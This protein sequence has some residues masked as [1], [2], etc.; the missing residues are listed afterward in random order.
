MAT[1]RSF[2]ELDGKTLKL[3]DEVIEVGDFVKIIDT[4][5]PNHHPL[6]LLK[7]MIDRYGGIWCRVTKLLD[8]ANTGWM[9]LET[10]DK[11]PIEFAWTKEMFSEHRKV[12]IESPYKGDILVDVSKSSEFSFTIDDIPETCYYHPY[13]IDQAIEQYSKLKK[14]SLKRAFKEVT[15]E[16]VGDWFYWNG[17][18][19]GFD[20]WLNIY[21]N[22]SFIPENYTPKYYKEVRFVF[23][24]HLTSDPLIDT[25]SDPDPTIEELQRKYL[26]SI[27]KE[28]VKKIEEE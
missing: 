10:I 12:L 27:K 20:Y 17:S 16:Q 8:G 5:D 9:K 19:Q 7:R 18:S 1:Y 25:P 24:P 3:K 26:E 22:P 4:Y 23:K 6:G 13:V 14:T 21:K 11:K 15:S 28:T 2:E